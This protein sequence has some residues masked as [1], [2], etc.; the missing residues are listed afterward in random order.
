MF[1]FL[2]I[3]APICVTGG[4]HITQRV[5]VVIG[6]IIGGIGLCLCYLL[7]S[8][9]YV[10][11]MFGVFYGENAVKHLFLAHLSTKCSC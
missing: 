8:M 4:Q 6:G 1:F 10:I 2:F 5:V 7:F 9:E 11:V 3:S